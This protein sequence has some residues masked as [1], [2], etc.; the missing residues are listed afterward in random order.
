M[1]ILPCFPESDPPVDLVTVDG[2]SSS[3]TVDLA[4]AVCASCPV[5]VRCRQRVLQIDSAGFA[6][7]MTQDE[8]RT[9]QE[10]HN[11][12][13]ESLSIVDVTPAHELTTEVLDD[14]PRSGAGLAPEVIDVV[15]RMSADGVTAG[16]IVAR[17][18]RPDVTHRTVNYIRRTYAK[19]VTRVDT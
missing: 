15:L 7:G 5:L 9:W 16:D 13:V 17:L 1:R 8:R 14:L 6:G 19:G 11:V 4:R 3:T 18:R 10:R 12:I 2:S